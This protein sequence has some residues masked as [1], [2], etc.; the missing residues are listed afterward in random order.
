MTPSRRPQ[1][2]FRVQDLPPEDQEKFVQT[3]AKNYR[4]R[5]LVDERYSKLREVDTECRRL[6][7]DH[8]KATRALNEAYLRVESLEAELSR[9]REERRAALDAANKIENQEFDSERYV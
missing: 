6:I 7:E 8:D 2:E 5:R 4:L 1:T 9:K 3:L